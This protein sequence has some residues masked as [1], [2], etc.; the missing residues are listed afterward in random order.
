M[1]GELLPP[2]C[3]RGTARHRRIGSESPARKFFL[4]NRVRP[5]FGAYFVSVL[6]DYITT[7]FEAKGDLLILKR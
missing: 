6:M 4:V 3:T 5:I 2:N 1:I 7:G